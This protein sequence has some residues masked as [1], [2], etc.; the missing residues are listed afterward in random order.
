VH[1]PSDTPATRG[2]LTS[3][4]LALVPALLATA[5]VWQRR[6]ISDDGFINMR[7]IA[8]LVAGRGPLY[9]PNERVEVGTSTLWLALTWAGQVIAPGS[10]TGQVMVVLGTAL[11]ALAFL[12][13][14]LGALALHSGPGGLLVPAGLVALAV[15]PPVWDFGTSGLETSL[16][17]AWIA[18]CFAA[19]AFRARHSD[20]LPAWRPWPVALLIG[21]GVLVRPDFALLSVC[22]AVAL[23]WQSRNRTREWVAAAGIAL[24]LPVGYEVFR[25]GYYAALVPNTALAKA[26]GSVQQGLAYLAD[27]VGVYWL[28]VPLAA[29]AWLLGSAL[30]RRPAPAVRA[31]LVVFPLTALLHTGFVVGVG[32]D[33]MHGRFLLPATWLL[34]APV[35]LVPFRGLDRAAVAVVLAWSAVCG[36]LLRPALWN[37]MIADERSYYARFVPDVPGG[38]VELENWSADLG[39]QLTR[40]AAADHAA[41]KSYY[42]QIE[43]PDEPLPRT[44]GV[45]VVMNSLGVAGMAAGL[46]VIVNDPPSL[47]DPIGSRLVLPPGATF[48]VGH[49]YKPEV[50]A[51]ARYAEGDRSEPIP[52]LDRARTVL[53]CAP[54][55]ELL[56]AV[57]DPLT[58]GRF[59]QNLTL[60]PRLTFLRI[61]VDPDEAAAALC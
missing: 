55:D 57:S 16:S 18:G 51:A 42:L 58:P 2:R 56:H 44:D 15:L 31:V 53:A 34:L 22:F 27:F 4:A 59:W 17:M 19:L 10:S 25:M 49:A 46:D 21:L 45:V 36:P 60:A 47:G 52:G 24:A 41:G 38:S 50:W 28:A 29:A 37:G 9:N 54:V 6:W 23:L 33:F 14:A 40:R 12:L 48:R 43:H 3:L 11:T 32:G 39:F 61:P 1:T 13:L 5:L 20:R 8:Q 26:N 7:V 35:A 30:W